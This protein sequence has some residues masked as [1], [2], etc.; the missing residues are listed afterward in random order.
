I[1]I[2]EYYP[3]IPRHD[4]AR[5]LTRLTP[6][7]HNIEITNLT[8]VG[9]KNAGVIVGLPESPIKTITLT[10]VHI[11]AQTGMTISDATVTA[12]D[13]TVKVAKG[14]PFTMVENA[15]IVKK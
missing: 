14:K 9:A 4:T 2:T 12:H 3:K 13:F 5:P 10:N 1:L 8:A 7:F 11:S 15:K 6:H